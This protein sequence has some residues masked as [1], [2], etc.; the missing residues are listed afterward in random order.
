[1]MQATGE[2]KIRW[3]SGRRDVE[4]ALARAAAAARCG[5]AV[6]LPTVVVALCS[7]AALCV[8][9]VRFCAASIAAFGA[10]APAA[11]SGLRPRRPSFSSHLKR[12]A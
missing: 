12:G 2:E 3:S 8:S 9:S 10:W 5:G 4:A 6:E 11:F 7:L 1:M